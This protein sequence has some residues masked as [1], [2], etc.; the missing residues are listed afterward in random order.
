[1]KNGWPGIAKEAEDIC[2]E[3]LIEDVITTRK[4]KTECSKEVK[5]AV[6]VMD[7]LNM[8][9]DMGDDDTGMKKMRVMRKDDCSLKE[10]MKT[11]TV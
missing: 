7:E 6:K 3:L 8:K 5:E 9:K 10:Y 2:E 4:S 1:M 11:G